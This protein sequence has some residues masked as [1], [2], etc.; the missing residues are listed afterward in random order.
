[1]A[2]DALKRQAEAGDFAAVTRPGSFEE[3]VAE[4]EVAVRGIPPNLGGHGGEH[5][6]LVFGGVWVDDDLPGFLGTRG[7]ALGGQIALV[8]PGITDCGAISFSLSIRTLRCFRERREIDWMPRLSWP[9]IHRQASRPTPSF[10]IPLYSSC[11]WA[12]LRL[13]DRLAAAA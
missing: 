6:E 11:W 5:A 10:R 7:G 12:R 4:A 8:D 13:W 2:N 3:F 9:A 1:L